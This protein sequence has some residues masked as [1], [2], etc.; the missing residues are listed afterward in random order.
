MVQ[1][2]AE[3]E[4]ELA[5]VVDEVAHLLPAQGPITVFVHHNT[6][7][8]FEQLRFEEAVVR[9][10]EVFG[11]E[12]FM[13]EDYYRAELRRGRITRGDVDTM[14][15]RALGAAGDERLL[16]PLTRRELRARVLTHG[17]PELRGEALKWT[18]GETE[19]LE[20][21]RDDVPAEV[22]EQVF[23]T[24][25]RSEDFSDDERA[26]VRELWAACEA[27]VE[28]LGPPLRRPAPPLRSRHRDLIA[29]ACGIDLDDWIHPVLIRFVS[30]FLDQGLAQWSMSGRERGMYACFL[31]T[32]DSALA[33]LCGPWAT[34]LPSL[35]A[36]ERRRGASSL[37][38]LAESLTVLGVDEPEWD[39]FLSATVLAL[40][41]FAGMVRQ[42]EE[43]PDR[44]PA[45]AVPAKLVD[46]LAVRLLLERSAIAHAARELGYHGPLARLREHLRERAVV[47]ELASCVSD[48][49]ALEQQT[50]GQK[51]DQ[52]GRHRLG[53]HAIG[54]L[55]ELPNHAREAA[56]RQ[57]RRRQ[58][59]VPLRLV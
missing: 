46:F 55:L 2:T 54:S 28:R 30:A 50:H 43:R 3:S 56:Q 45:H 31:D 22:R 36:V 15:T 6:L 7:H 17:I 40:R 52:L 12:P 13:S 11:C 58:E 14:L 27:G 48:G 20:R 53:R 5:S 38:S 18:L 29:D 32:F 19:A 35:L 21:L 4:R 24:R 51:V 59:L 57:H 41:G 44:V 9:A 33:G 49:R 42:L 26:V 23:A 34:Q 1:P 8:A 47:A 39:E 10:G 37:D 25:G 16:E